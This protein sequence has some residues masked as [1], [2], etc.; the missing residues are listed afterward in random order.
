MNYRII[1]IIIAV[2]ITFGLTPSIAAVEDPISISTS[3]DLYY[4]NDV[5]VVF[6]KVTSTLGGLPVTIQLYHEDSLIAV[7]QVKIALDG[8]FATDFIAK[9]HYWSDDGTYIVRAFYTQDKIA[10]KSF[11][12]FKKPS[13]GTSSLFPVNIPNSGSFDLGYSI[14]GGEVNDIIL[15]QDHYSLLIEINPNSNGDIVLKLPRENIESKTTDGI[16]EAFIILISKT[17]FDGADF[18][19]VQFEEIETGSNFRTVRI[20]F[21]EDD[22]WIEVIGTHV[23]PEFG[24]IVTMIL[25]IAVTTTIIISKSKF[26]I[27]YN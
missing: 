22:R 15:N 25:L 6:G 7:D 19:E 27:K 2:G 17:G 10:E 20:Q 26:S 12:F 24:T 11:Q 14:L 9:G 13:S 16:D 1:F 23:I 8:T 5:I 4:E 3:K 21:E 18:T